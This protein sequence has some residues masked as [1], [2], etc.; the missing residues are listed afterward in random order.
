MHTALRATVALVLLGASLMITDLLPARSVP[1]DPVNVFKH[2]ERIVYKVRWWI[3]RLGTIVVTT[4]KIEDTTATNAYRVRV[5]LESDP[6]IFFLSVKSQYESVIT[7]SPLRCTQF[8]GYEIDGKDTLVTLYVANDSLR[9]VRME[10]WKYP[11]GMKVREKIVDGLDAFYEG[12]SLVFLARKMLHSNLQIVAPTVVDM[13]FFTT[14][15]NFTEEVSS[16]SIDAYPHPISVKELNG[17][18]NFSGK[19]LA[20]FS[21]DFRGFFSNDDAAIPVKAEMNITLG[22][23]HVELE[24]WSRPGWTPPSPKGK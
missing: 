24:H 4:E 9:Q 14:N 5:S 13:Q 3:F 7:V 1:D 19:S 8:I 17:R 15:I 18:A 11:A 12:A 20:G 23:A 10:E 2:G 21:G 16:L 22:R 6:S